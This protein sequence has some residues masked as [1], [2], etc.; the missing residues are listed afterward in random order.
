MGVVDV[1][2]PSGPFQSPASE[3]LGSWKEI[4]AYLKR[5]ESTVRRWEDEGLPVHRLPHK[6]KATVY[7]YKSELDV[8][9]NAGRP[10]L[11]AVA[12][13]EPAL[14]HTRVKWVTASMV[15]L[16]AAGLAL[17]VVLRERVFGPRAG[18]IASIAVLPLK[19]LSG[20]SGQDYFADGMTEA[21]ITELGKISA[22]QVL[23]HQSVSGYRQTAKP[24][25]E[26]AR[27]LKV[28]ALIE[29]TVLHSGNRVR[30]TTNLVQAAPERHL[31]AQSY[32]FDGQDVL[33][34]QGAVARYVASR[35]RIKVTA[36]EQARLTSSRR[37]DPEAY[38]AY[39]LGRAYWCNGSTPGNGKRAREYFE[40]AI[41]KDPGYAP[42]Y[43]SL[44]E[45]S[46]RVTRA[47][48]S[49]DTTRGALG[50]TPLGRHRPAARRHARRGAQ[51]ARQ[52]IAAGVGLGGCGARVPARHRPEPELCGRAHLVHHVSLRHATLRRGDGPGQTRSAAGPGVAARQ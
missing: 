42:A 40:K 14:S 29:G 10:R 25:P 41:Q 36:Q 43:A 48:V 23:S 16:V 3:R 47:D 20:D 49:A 11:D 7:A 30:I 39:L 9:W 38:E 24:L 1:S 28:D 31:W 17:T 44:A 21:L 27:E 2:T 33:A 34:V 4:A 15:L 46:L 19:S 35:I 8:W 18:E 22:L 45:L 5:D 26:I 6:K 13:T 50:G 37:V 52:G 32:E 12:T 51:R